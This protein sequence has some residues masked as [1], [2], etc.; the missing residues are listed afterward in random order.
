MIKEHT[1][2]YLAL[3]IQYWRRSTV[4]PT[5]QCTA[6]V[7]TRSH[8]RAA[9][10]RASITINNVFALLVRMITRH[11]YCRYDKA[12]YVVVMGYS[13]LS[14]ADVRL[15][16]SISESASKKQRRLTLPMNSAKAP[17]GSPQ[18][19]TADSAVLSSLCC[20]RY[21]IRLY[22]FSIWLRTGC[23]PLR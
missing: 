23:N 11:Y 4:D 2:A 20:T 12:G 7:S 8:L 15:P 22:V 14:G 9:N 17:A 18:T 13:C 6:A 3:V 10:L 1:Q 21:N 16:R 5:P 19:K